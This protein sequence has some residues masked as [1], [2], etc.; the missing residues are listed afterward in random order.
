MTQSR[1]LVPVLTGA[2]LL[3]VG[4]YFTGDKLTGDASGAGCGG[5]EVV[6]VE[7]EVG[8][9]DPGIDA[10]I[11]ELAAW[12]QARLADPA[13][14]AQ[15]DAK[16]AEVVGSGLDALPSLVAVIQTQGCNEASSLGLMGA[17]HDVIAAADAGI[18]ASDGVANVLVTAASQGFTTRGTPAETRFSD[19]EGFDKLAEDVLAA[20]PGQDLP[21]LAEWAD[22]TRIW[23]PIW[24]DDTTTQCASRALDAVVALSSVEAF[25]R[26]IVTIEQV[27]VG[28]PSGARFVEAAIA[29]IDVHPESAAAMQEIALNPDLSLPARGLGCSATQWPP[30][31]RKALDT[32]LTDL[33]TEEAAQLLSECNLPTTATTVPTLAGMLKE[34]MGDEADPDPVCNKNGVLCDFGPLAGSANALFELVEDDE[35]ARAELRGRLEAAVAGADPWQLT[36][37]Q[38]LAPGAA[39]LWPTAIP[40]LEY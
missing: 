36:R 40:G 10:K 33:T 23:E 27:P 28:H 39:Q 25:D 3:G 38:V 9:S 29:L 12:D 6:D 24:E 22:R 1:R 8:A 17:L 15:F 31:A 7:S 18:P 4:V 26:L 21:A 19:Y 20:E 30:D 32:Q 5:G 11:A 13:Q 35:E 37:L 16:I 34:I 14:A 2:L